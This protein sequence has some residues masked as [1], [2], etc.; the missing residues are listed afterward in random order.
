MRNAPV[1]IFNASHP[2]WFLRLKSKA[3]IHADG[4]VAAAPQSSLHGVLGSHEIIKCMGKHT[5]R[6][7]QARRSGADPL[8]MQAIS[9]ATSAF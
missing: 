7:E 6:L 1:R 2:L 4:T 3:A 8:S 9:P 5:Q